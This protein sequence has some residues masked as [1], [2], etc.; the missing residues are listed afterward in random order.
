MVQL[1]TFIRIV[2]KTKTSHAQVPT[3]GVVVVVVL[4]L[5]H[6]L[7]SKCISFPAPNNSYNKMNNT[8]KNLLLGNPKLSLSLGMILY[9]EIFGTIFSERNKA[10]MEKK[11]IVDEGEAFRSRPSSK[12]LTVQKSNFLVPSKT[13]KNLEN[14][15]VN[16]SAGSQ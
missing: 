10:G 12:C 16:V 11:H 1:I 8:C 9:L 13:N 3:V 2:G 14:D 4:Y 7:L 15:R 6:L 5:K